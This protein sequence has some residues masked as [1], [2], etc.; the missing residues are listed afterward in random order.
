M[1]KWPYLVCVVWYRLFWPVLILFKKRKV[2]WNVLFIYFSAIFSAYGQNLPQHVSSIPQTL[3]TWLS[4]SVENPSASPNLCSASSPF[5]RYSRP[6]QR[7][8]SRR[9]V[10]SN[11]QIRCSYQCPFH[12]ID[13]LSETKKIWSEKDCFHMEFG[14][15]TGDVQRA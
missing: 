1:L 6:F 13:S 10:T 4:S 9:S 2:L 12:S 14:W 5:C 8:R 7:E 3:R 11:G 15:K